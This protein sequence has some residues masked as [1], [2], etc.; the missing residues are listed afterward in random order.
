MFKPARLCFQA[1]PF[2]Y[3]LIARSVVLVL[4]LGFCAACSAQSAGNPPTSPGDLRDD[5]SPWGVATGAEWLNDYPKFNPML[6]QAGIR[7]L[8]G[9]YE[10]Q[11]IQPRPGEWNFVLP[12]R[13]LENARSNGLHLTGMFAYF[14]PWASAD[15]G[16]RRFP[17]KDIR[18]WRDY[19]AALV[20]RY[21]SD[22][23][24]WEVWNEFNGS[25]AV[26]GS[27]EIYAELVREAFI[28]A[29]KIDPTAK[30]GMSVANFDVRFLDATIKAGAAN[31]FDYICVHPY[32]ILAG[33]RQGGEPAFLNMTTTL[34]KM[35]DANRQSADTPLWIT[36]IGALAPVKRDDVEDQAQAVALAKA[37]LLSIVAGFQRVFWFEARGPSYGDGKDHGLIRSDMTARPSLDALGVLTAALGAEPTSAGWLDF[38]EGAFAFAFNNGGKAVLGAWA[39]AKRKVN[40]VFDGDV[41]LLSLKGESTTL[42]AGDSLTLTDTPVLIEGLPA[43]LVE[44]ARAQQKQPFPWKVDYQ[45]AEL[46]TL[47]LGERNIGTGIRSINQDTTIADREWRRLDFSRSDKEGHYVYFW[48]DPQFAG[49]EA[50]SIEVTTVVK[51][52]AT[53]KQAGLSIDYES[54]RGYVGTD[55]RNIPAS[56]AW[57]EL[58]WALKDTSFAGAWG[59]SFRINAISSPNEFL[60]K[61]VR[62]RKIR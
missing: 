15:G 6:R 38:G 30:I 18:F 2:T 13:L 52:V 17:I 28:S 43:A 24:Y 36:E 53:D 60:I 25:F 57:Q 56:D 1:R 46:A 14:A 54:S 23:K 42:R 41:R 9:F 47:L 58:S 8:R 3:L 51:R 7:W 33:L 21:H 10:W 44:K 62:I 12:D 27:P 26:D 16:T 40:V 34:R 61:E 39:G 4:G 55:Y 29:K 37:Y 22:I 31:H 11:T 45:G 19:V 50:K 48:V 59:W 32:E 49:L 5:R 35:L 20:T